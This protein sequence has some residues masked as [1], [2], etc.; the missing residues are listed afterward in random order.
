MDFE[1]LPEF[2][3]RENNDFTP[4]ELANAIGKHGQPVEVLHRFTIDDFDNR[5]R[6]CFWVQVAGNTVAYVT[7]VPPVLL[8]YE[9]GYI[10]DRY[11]ASEGDDTPRCHTLVVIA[12]S[13]AATMRVIPPPS[14]PVK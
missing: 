6:Y 10:V 11:P 13:V 14:E 4:D 12:A 5:S 3:E 1:D 9:W 2:T 7:Q 8:G